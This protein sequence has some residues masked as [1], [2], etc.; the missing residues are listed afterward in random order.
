MEE[1][2]HDTET[3]ET[4]EIIAKWGMRDSKNIRKTKDYLRTK[5]KRKAQ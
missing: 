1:F 4:D 5:Q 3:L 2:L